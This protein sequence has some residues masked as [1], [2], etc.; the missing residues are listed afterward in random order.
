ML[1][2]VPLTVPRVGRSYEHFPD[3]FYLH[4]LQLTRI[5]PV[6]SVPSDRF[7]R[8]ND[9]TKKRAKLSL[10]EVSLALFLI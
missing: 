10:K 2:I 9:Q 4:L 6:G 3:G 1:R 8:W 7:L 5:L